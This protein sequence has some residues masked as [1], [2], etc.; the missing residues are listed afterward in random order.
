MDNKRQNRFSKLIQKEL[1]EIFQRDAKSLFGSAFITVTHVNVSPDLG[2]AKIYLS[3]LMEKDKKGLLQNIKTQTKQIRLLLGNK[4][5]NQARV[6]P[7]L[8]FYYD[9]NLDYAAKMDELFSKIDI[10]P[11]SD[12]D[13]EEKNDN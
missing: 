3:F 12:E 7:E 4:I 2:V 9:D 13:K 1:G 11:A 8:I 5:R 10:P 6:I